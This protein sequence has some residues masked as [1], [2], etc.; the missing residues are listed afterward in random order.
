MVGGGWWLHIE[1]ENDFNVTFLWHFCWWL[2]VG[3]WCVVVGGAG[4]W[5]VV[6]GGFI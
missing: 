3:G 1:N 2:V 4:G 6:A 5:W